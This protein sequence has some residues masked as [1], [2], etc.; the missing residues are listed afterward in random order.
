MP[1]P[2][3]AITA[4]F[5]IKTVIGPNDYASMREVLTR[6]VDLGTIPVKGT[7]RGK[8]RKLHRFPDILMMMDGGQAVA[9]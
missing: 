6:R 3:P 2:K 9:R 5:N 4:N 7:G 1:K 8:V